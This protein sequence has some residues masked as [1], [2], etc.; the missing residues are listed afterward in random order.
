MTHYPGLPRTEESLGMHEGLSCQYQ[1]SSRQIKMIGH[2][3][4]A[5]P[6]HLQ[7]IAIEYFYP[8]F[9]NLYSSKPLYLSYH[10][11]VWKWIQI[12]QSRQESINSVNQCCARTNLH[13]LTRADFTHFF[14]TLHLLSHANRLLPQ[15]ENWHYENQQVLQIWASLPYPQP[16]NLLL[17]IYQHTSA[18]SWIEKVWKTSYCGDS[19][20]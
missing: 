15:W 6:Y 2:P 9:R 5:I 16:Q 13:Q 7:R 4:S 14:K 3:K 19:P 17:N 11:V 10:S 8:E 18:I 1:E 12:G 20:M